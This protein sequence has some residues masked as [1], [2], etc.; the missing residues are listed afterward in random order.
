MLLDPRR[1]DLNTAKEISGPKPHPLTT[2][3]VL[4]KYLKP[5]SVIAFL[6]SQRLF[7]RP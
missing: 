7:F 4:L 1:W 3:L 6:A 2:N 5:K